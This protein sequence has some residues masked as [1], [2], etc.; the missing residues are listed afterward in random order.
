MIRYCDKHPVD[1][2]TV[3]TR[4][5]TDVLTPSASL[6]QMLD[7][8]NLQSLSSSNVTKCTDFTI[9]QK[10]DETLAHYWRLAEAGAGNYI[11]SDGVLVK[12]TPPHINSLCDKLLVVPALQIW[13]VDS[14]HQNTRVACAHV[15]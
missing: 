9:A 10:A 2:A 12:L 13:C 5:S 15:S 8:L 3:E 6:S 1:G 14:A 4:N 11:I 7:G